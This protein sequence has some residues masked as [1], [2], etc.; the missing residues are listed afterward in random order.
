MVREMNEYLL[1]NPEYM[2]KENIELRR[3]IKYLIEDNEKN[4]NIIK[5]LKIYLETHAVRLEQLK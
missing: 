3:Q 1:E 4:R 2:L 5:E